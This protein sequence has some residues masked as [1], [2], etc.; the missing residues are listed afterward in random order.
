MST[1]L[2]RGRHA[3]A[4]DR[5]D[6][7]KCIDMASGTIK[8]EGVHVTPAGRNPQA[9]LVWLA[10]TDRALI[11]NEKGELILARLTPAKFTEL[12]KIKV[13]APPKPGDVIWAHPAYARGAIF[14]RSDAELVCVP[15]VP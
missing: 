7:L 10:D 3:Y 11:F 9:S 2:I 4:I 6:G 15:I 12:G 14:A 13:M 1:P 5:R 8:W